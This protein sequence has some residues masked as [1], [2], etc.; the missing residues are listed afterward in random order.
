M[1]PVHGN[2]KTFSSFPDDDVEDILQQISDLLGSQIGDN[3]QCTDIDGWFI[4]IYANL[5]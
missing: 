3:S 4:F 1:E 2:Y 5:P